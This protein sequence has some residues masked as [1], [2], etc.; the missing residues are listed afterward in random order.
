MLGHLEGLK[1]S[2]WLATDD[3]GA[4]KALA[5]PTLTF[6]VIEKTLNDQGDFTGI[7]NRSVFLAPASPGAN[8]GFYYG[9]LSTEAHPFLLSADSYQ[10]LA[11]EL[12]AN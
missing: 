1:V 7:S 5:A 10:K 6:S 8:P 9:R 4:L 2:R 3:E 11:V 12:F